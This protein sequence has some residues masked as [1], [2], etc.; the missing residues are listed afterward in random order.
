M[1]EIPEATPEEL[2]ALFEG[3]KSIPQ[4]EPCEITDD[5]IEH[6]I[7]KECIRSADRKMPEEEID[8][9]ATDILESHKKTT[10]LFEQATGMGV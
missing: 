1:K 8:R 2:D 9:W 3:Q 7:L 5:T 6:G 10:K 4:E